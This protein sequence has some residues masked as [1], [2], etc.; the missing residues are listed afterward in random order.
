MQGVGLLDRQQ[1]KQ[2]QDASINLDRDERIDI[3]GISIDREAPASVRAEQFLSQ[4]KNPY[5]FKCGDVAVNLEFS[6]E[7]K[8]LEQAMTSYFLSKK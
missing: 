7:G 4:I 3:H 2:L 5:A 1:L 6:S 8:T